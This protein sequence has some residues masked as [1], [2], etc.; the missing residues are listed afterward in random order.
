RLEVPF[1]TVLHLEAIHGDVHDELPFMMPGCRLAV[2]SLLAGH[3]SGLPARCEVD[4]V[5]GQECRSRRRRS[6]PGL[7]ERAFANG[8][9]LDHVW[10]ALDGQRPLLDQFKQPGMQPVPARCGEFMKTE[11]A[12]H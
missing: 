6:S 5:A 11:E 4:Y 12:G 1:R 3:R 10:V 8:V 2:R 7:G 9:K